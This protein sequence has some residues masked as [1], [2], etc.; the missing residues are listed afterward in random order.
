MLRSVT[1]LLLTRRVEVVRAAADGLYNQHG[2]KKI[3]PRACAFVLMLG[4]LLHVA[5]VVGEPFVP[6]GFPAP[7][8]P[9]D[10]PITAAKA[11]LGRHLFYDTRLS[12]NEKYSCASCHI[13][14]RAF[15]D[16]RV[17]AVGATG[18]LHRHNTMAIA[19]AAY[20]AS[21][22]W[23]DPKLVRLEDQLRIPLFGIKPVEM[24]LT[25]PLPPQLVQ[26]L[27]RDAYY[28]SA[29]VRAFPGERPMIDAQHIIKALAS[30]VRTIVSYRSPLDRLLFADDHTALDATAQ[31]GMRLFFSSRLACASCHAGVNLGG[32]LRTHDAPRISPVLRNNGLY[33]VDG[34]GSYPVGD[35]GAIEHTHRARDMGAFRIPTLRNIALTAPYMHDGTLPTL[36]AVLDHY[37]RGGHSG[38]YRSAQV[39]GFTLTQQE[40]RDLLAFLNALTDHVLLADSRYGAPH[41][42][43]HFSSQ[44]SPTRLR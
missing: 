34:K 33:D 21:F 14:A 9:S 11:E 42:R 3:L 43:T 36:D 5:K 29:F 16:G 38:R 23:N 26:A 6:A 1:G 12:V 25:D 32:P 18:Q 10:N 17:R 35:T 15:T 37:A 2:I 39:R 44:Q 40:R 30:F 7:L 20:S 31:R 8:V 28:G 19:N 13:Q 27:A 24:G 4:M 22:G 41:T